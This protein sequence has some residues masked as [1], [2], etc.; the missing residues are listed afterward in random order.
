MP[1]GRI[2]GS[3]QVRHHGLCKMNGAVQI[4]SGMSLNLNPNHR[5]EQLATL[6]RIN[7]APGFVYFTVLVLV[8]RMAGSSTLDTYG[9]I[10]SPS[11]CT[12]IMVI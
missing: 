4:Y 3:I 7:A 8:V 11:P 5:A 10:S 2:D 9:V 12:N 6:I 1:D